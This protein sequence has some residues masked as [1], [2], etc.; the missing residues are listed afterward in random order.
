ML[1][2]HAQGICD[3]GVVRDSSAGAVPLHINPVN[4]SAV[5][6]PLLYGSTVKYTYVEFV[7]T[8][9]RSVG[10]E[11]T[12]SGDDGVTKVYSTHDATDRVAYAGAGLSRAQVFGHDALN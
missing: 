1:P 12:C 5:V 4:M 10:R 3:D 8:K 2:G 7:K 9:W 6:R 11:F